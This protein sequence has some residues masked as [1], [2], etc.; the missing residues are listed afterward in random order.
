[1]TI[2]PVFTASKLS[3][4]FIF[5]TQWLSYKGFTSGLSIGGLKKQ[6]WMIQKW[7]NIDGA[8]SVVNAVVFWHFMQLFVRKACDMWQKNQDKQ[9]VIDKSYMYYEKTCNTPSESVS[10][11]AALKGSW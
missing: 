1:M 6:F 7:L 2:S 10:T 9:M 5:K 11:L 8:F 4:P 3:F